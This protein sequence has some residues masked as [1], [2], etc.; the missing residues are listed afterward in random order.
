MKTPI[1]LASFFILAFSLLGGNGSCNLPV[2]PC[3]TD[4]PA[5]DDDGE[6]PLVTIADEPTRAS[7]PM[8]ALGIT[9]WD[10]ACNYLYLKVGYSGGCVQHDFTYIA[11]DTFAES[12]PVQI[13]TWIS[14]EDY[15]DACDS[16]LLEE[17][18]YDL[19]PIR[20]L[21]FEAYGSLDP[22]VVNLRDADGSI[23]LTFQYD[24]QAD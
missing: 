1:C 20:D 13:S 9:E 3:E 5:L 15:D 2:F 10:Q 24:P 23:V 22:I 4:I 16:V 12:F 21:Y 11:S 7:F 17:Q 6:I 19:T 18:V 8:D 14:H